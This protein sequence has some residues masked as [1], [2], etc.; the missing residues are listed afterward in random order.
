MSQTSIHPE[1]LRRVADVV[2][3]IGSLPA[4]A[5][6]DWCERAAR[7]LLPLRT[8]AVACVLMADLSD[9]GE[10]LLNEAS[11]VVH[12]G[13]G[14]ETIDGQMIHPAVAPSLGWWINRTTENAPA[15]ALL[16]TLPDAAR[17]PESSAGRRWTRDFGVTDLVVGICPLK[18]E[19]DGRSIVVELGVRSE[20][21][22][23][24]A[25]DAA[26]VA[27]VI[28]PLA[29]RASLAFGPE[30]TNPLNRITP[31]EQLILEQLALGKTVKQIATSLSRSPHT[32]HD[33]VKSLHRKLNA[34]SRGELIAR[35]LGHIEMCAKTREAANGSLNARPMPEIQT[36][37]NLLQSA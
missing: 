11:G 8:D 7:C 30:A 5:T 18:G 12:G 14:G 31:R 37:P 27:A 4:V 24:E 15:A 36:R 33:H 22:P 19:A 28:E 13:Q 17:W 26:T 10:V 6:Q 2:T 35:A 29:R 34:S 32:V 16:R 20:A 9:D 21:Q 23:F 3:A 25:P 1:H